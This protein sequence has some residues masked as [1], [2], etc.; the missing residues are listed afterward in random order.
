[1]L[2]SLTLFPTARPSEPICPWMVCWPY[3]AP[4]SLRT[5]LGTSTC[6]LVSGLLG[7]STISLYS[8]IS[9]SPWHTIISSHWTSVVLCGKVHMSTAYSWKG[10]AGIHRRVS[11]RSLTSRNLPLTCLGPTFVWTFN[12]KTKEKSAKWAI[13]GVCLLLSIWR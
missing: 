4:E 13:A 11:F 3:Y 10:L 6:L 1:M 5:G 2:C 9:C 12:L 7:S 8:L